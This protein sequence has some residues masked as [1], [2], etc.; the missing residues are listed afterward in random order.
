MNDDTGSQITYREFRLKTIRVAQNLLKRDFKPREVFG[1]L[2]DHS[3][4]LVPILLASVCLACPIAP[5]HQMLSKD[6]IV[7]F[8]QKAKPSVVFC[9]FG[10]CDQLGEALKEL[11]FTVKVFT[12]GGQV[13]GFEP[14]EN[15]FIETGEE[16]GFV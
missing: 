6:E 5:L 1:F 4:H 10:A 3:D 2:A 14:V 9:D 8:Y 13:E 15:L 11:P 7:R 12:F 16:N